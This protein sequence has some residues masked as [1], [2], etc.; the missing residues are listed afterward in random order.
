[1]AHRFRWTHTLADGSESTVTRVVGDHETGDA[2]A[3]DD[4]GSDAAPDV[5]SGP[6]RRYDWRLPESLPVETPADDV[7]LER[8]GAR[9]TVIVPDGV[10]AAH[11]RVTTDAGTSRL[12]LLDPTV[13]GHLTDALRGDDE[14]AH[15]LANAFGSAV[16]AVHACAATLDIEGIVDLVDA[17]ASADGDASDD[18]HARRY[19]LCRAAAL[20]TNGLALARAAEFERLAEGLDS[21]ADIGDVDT[22]DALGDLVAV[23]GL[24]PVRDLGYDLVRLA[25]REDGR[26]EAYW[27]AAVARGRPDGATERASASNAT[28][29]QD[30]LEAARD[31][32]S[33]RGADGEYGRL[34]DRAADADYHE[35]GAAWRALCGPASRRS[36]SEFAYVLANAC[37]WTGEVGRTDARADELCYDGAIAA[38]RAEGIEWITAHARY[39]R[40]RAVGHRHRSARNHAFAVAA[41]ERAR[42]VAVE[43]DY[44]GLTPWDP[45][46]SRTV[47]ASNAASAR[48]DHT[49]A[50]RIL[51]EGRDEIAALDPPAERFEEIRHH[52]DGQRHERL[53]LVARTEEDGA[54]ETHLEA[55]REHYAAV[56]FER[57]RERIDSKLEDARR[58]DTSDRRARAT[59]RAGPKPRP[60][61]D[62]RGPS[63]ADIPDLHDRLTE[64][65]PTAVGSADPGVV[66]RDPWDDPEP[67]PGRGY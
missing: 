5:E 15:A 13:G 24:E 31:V 34:K 23:H 7:T 12:T 61:T 14:A 59:G 6:R 38:A 18:L 50:V 39:E 3:T 33:G 16:A 56:G 58:E 44:D 53:A 55:A 52:L 67:G 66:E 57:S 43:Y 42:A 28:R 47:V 11:V 22:L 48:G 49:A 30:G 25:H 64:T 51:E 62:T 36:R 20:G 17:L 27:L 29:E 9:V 2:P 21:V 19:A 40:A 1:M 60:P 63:L 8:D 37:Y 65:D 32:A 10:G 35:R 26:F 4:T 45:L 46:Y 41:F 54:V